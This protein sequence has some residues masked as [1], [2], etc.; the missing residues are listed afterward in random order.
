MMTKALAARLAPEGIGVFELRPGIIRT[1]MTGPV[2]D[3]Y[4]ARIAEGSRSVGPLGGAFGHRQGDRPACP[5]RFRLR[6]RRCHP[7]GWRPVHP[8]SLRGPMAEGYDFIIIG[9]GSAGSV[10]AAR[11]TEDPSVRVC[12]LEAGG[13]D[14]NPLF[15]LP[16]GFAK[17]TKGVA[18]GG[19]ARCPSGTWAARSSPTPR[20]RS[21][22][23]ARDQ[24][25]D[26]HARQCAGL[27]RMAAD[28]V[29][30]LVLCRRAAL[31]PQVRGQRHLRQ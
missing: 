27:R 8:S 31:F 19:G 30:G 28:G 11:L 23:A 17:M 9:G 2:A 26:L 10:L 16:A 29:R 21:S 13:R 24:R 20:P 3:R 5:R 6:N 14:W 12:L 4:D 18:P 7:R 1:P 22:A 25:A 15:H